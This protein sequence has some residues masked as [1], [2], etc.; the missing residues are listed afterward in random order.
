MGITAALFG[1]G[2]VGYSNFERKRRK[3]QRLE[4]RRAALEEK[5]LRSLQPSARRGFAGGGSLLGNAPGSPN[6]GKSTLLGSG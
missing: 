1:G 3:N 2:P 5:R 4:E 6:L